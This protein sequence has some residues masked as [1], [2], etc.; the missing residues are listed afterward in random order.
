VLSN[1]VS[2]AVK[3]TDSGHVRIRA[4]VERIGGRYEAE[5]HMFVCFEVS[6]TG[7]GIEPDVRRRL[8]APFTQADQTFARNYGGTG[9]GLAISR[10]F[11]E[12]MGGDIGLESKPGAGSKFWFTVCL[13]L[14]KHTI[15]A[16]AIAS[17]P[18]NGPPAATGT[19]VLLAEDDPVNQRVALEML[20]ILGYDA[21]L[22]TNGHEVLR[23]LDRQPYDLV[24]MDCHMP[25]MD[26]FA[27]TETIRRGEDAVAKAGILLP[28]LPIIAFTANAMHGDRERCLA[29]GMDDYLTKPFRMEALVET[30]SRWLPGTGTLRKAA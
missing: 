19:R 4:A 15:P 26:G 27:A 25:E 5:N 11:V 21:V 10:K 3:F 23:A 30:L 7:I 14:A 12:L 29:A 2:N 24:L 17:A 8:F 9:L 16:D 20:C 18:Q 6:D 1:L 28:R 22:A 13:E